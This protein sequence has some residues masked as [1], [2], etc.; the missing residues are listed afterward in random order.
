MWYFAYILLWKE[1][2]ESPEDAL[3]QEVSGSIILFTKTDIL[4]YIIIAF[5]WRRRMYTCKQN[6]LRTLNMQLSM[7]VLIVHTVK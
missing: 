2:E 1:D 4:S 3:P 5:R 7:Y 6:D